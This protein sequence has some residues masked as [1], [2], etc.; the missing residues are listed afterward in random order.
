MNAQI[1]LPYDG[2]WA[3]NSST[4]LGHNRFSFPCQ[5]GQATPKDIISMRVLHHHVLHN[6]DL[7]IHA[8]FINP[9]WT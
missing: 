5:K 1:G 9:S 3:T 8:L 7:S 4:P 2:T 6:W